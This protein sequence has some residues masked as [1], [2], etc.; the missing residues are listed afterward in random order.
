[1]QGTYKRYSNISVSST[2]FNINV[3]NNKLIDDLVG[4]NISSR[5]LELSQRPFKDG[6]QSLIE[7]IL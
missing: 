6:F 5:L 2:Y 1:M 3:L 7:I 4:T